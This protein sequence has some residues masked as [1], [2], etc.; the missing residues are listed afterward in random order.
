MNFLI[1]KNQELLNQNK[2]LLEMLGRKTTLSAE[3]QKLKGLLESR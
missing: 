3:N 1:V 2:E